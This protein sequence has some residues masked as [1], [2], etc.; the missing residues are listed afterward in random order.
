MSASWD[1]ER[2]GDFLGWSEFT[3][4]IGNIK[5]GLG[6]SRENAVLRD[7]MTGLGE[8]EIQ[9]AL[10]DLERREAVETKKQQSLQSKLKDEME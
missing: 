2:E 6:R 1:P 8:D 3:R 10:A 4:N 9:S 7:K 5:E